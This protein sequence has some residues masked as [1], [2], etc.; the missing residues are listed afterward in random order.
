MLVN[1]VDVC[2]LSC[3][4]GTKNV[5]F[6]DHC[7][8][9]GVIDYMIHLIEL[10]HEPLDKQLIPL[11]IDTWLKIVGEVNLFSSC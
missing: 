6:N 3:P 11:N 4:L 7:P 10:R 8:K 2:G 5:W 1:E 9:V